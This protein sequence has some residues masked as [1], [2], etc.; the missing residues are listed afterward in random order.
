LLIWPRVS[1]IAPLVFALA[2]PLSEMA[3]AAFLGFAWHSIGYSMLGT[4]L[5]ALFSSIGVYGVA[6]LGALLCGVAALWLVGWARA[7]Q[8]VRRVQVF[9]AAGILLLFVVPFP[10]PPGDYLVTTKPAGAPSRARL[11]Q[12]ATAQLHKFDTATV[13]EVVQRLE[14]L[15][16]DPAAEL[17]VAPETVIPHSWNGLTSEISTPLMNAVSGSSRVLL[18]GTLEFDPTVGLFNVSAALRANSLDV[19][20]QSYVKRHLVPVAERSTLGLQWLTDAL[21]LPYSDRVAGSG[22][23]TVFDT[24]RGGVQ[25]TICLDLAYGADLS[26]TARVTNVIVNQSNLVALRGPRV[27]E[28]FTTIARVRALEQGKPVL[29]STNDGPTVAIETNGQVVAALPYG[30]AGAISVTIQPRAGATIYASVGEAGWIGALLLALLA[31]GAW[32]APR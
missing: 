20:P 5:S 25:A 12:P 15:A 21:A 24:P 18:I 2:Y 8:R 9:V 23:S 26:A 10:R 14:Q 30:R 31:V 28:Q 19:P 3:T 13:L 22:D 1:R 6:A 16:R 11:L 17:V 29:V 7:S 32:R 4:P 27:R